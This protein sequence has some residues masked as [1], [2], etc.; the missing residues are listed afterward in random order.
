VKDWET[1][2]ETP[3]LPL[4][5]GRVRTAIFQFGSRDTFT[6][7]YKNEITQADNI[8][9]FLHAN[10]VEAETDRTARTVT[11][12]RIAGMGG[13]ENW[14]KAKLFILAMGAIEIPRLLLLSNRSRKNGLGNEND[15][16][17]R[18]FMEHPH[19]WSGLYKPSDPGMINATALYRVHRLNEV[20]IM[21]KLTIAEEVLRREKLLNYCVSIHPDIMPKRANIMPSFKVIS[22]PLLSSNGTAGSR[23]CDKGAA[24]PRHSAGAAVGEVGLAV[25]RK[26]RRMSGRVFNAARKKKPTVIFRLNHMTDR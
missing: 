10:V 16:V 20:P 26:A 21:G 8:T 14:I 23:G 6:R 1:P 9:T 18:F 3:R 5:D 7:E 11:R 25:Y 19:L 22:M 15:L 17:G 12:L 4:D 24:A 2:G 13:K